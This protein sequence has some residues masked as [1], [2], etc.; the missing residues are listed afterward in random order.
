MDNCLFCKIGRGEIKP[1]VIWEN[2]SYIAFLDANPIAPGHTLVIPKKHTEY[3]FDLENK[4]Y[5][6]LML[7][8]KNIAKTL[9]EKLHPKRVGIL[10]EGFGVNHVHVHLVPINVGGGVCLQYSK[11]AT[12]DELKKIAEKLI[13]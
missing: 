8:S 13:K 3:I 10:V 2:D 11:H 5:S 4:G 12:A 9:K 1:E 7:A 6:D